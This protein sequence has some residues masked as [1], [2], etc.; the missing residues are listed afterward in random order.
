MI[1]D[2]LS[3]TL[4]ITFHLSLITYSEGIFIHHKI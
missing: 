3:L 4:L 1:G 2:K